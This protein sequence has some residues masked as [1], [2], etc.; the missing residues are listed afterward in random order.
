MPKP[1]KMIRCQGE[2][3]VRAHAVWQF[4]CA[5][6]QLIR[7]AVLAVA[8]LVVVAAPVG[9]VP[10]TTHDDWQLADDALQTIMQLVTVE[11]CASLTVLAPA[12]SGDAKASTEKADRANMLTG[13][14]IGRS[15]RGCSA[16]VQCSVAPPRWEREL[17]PSADALASHAD[18]M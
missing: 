12:A 17:C 14:F 10:G 15:A 1:A 2:G 7:H 3:D 6:V 11:L 13:I 8:L 4:N 16:G 9:G 18:W 5:V